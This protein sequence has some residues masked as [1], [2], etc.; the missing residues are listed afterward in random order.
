MKKQ[1]V[2]ALAL[3]AASFGATAGEL[4]YSYV[5]GGYARTHIDNLGNGDG[6]GVDGSVAVSGNIHIFGGYTMQSASED[7]IDVDLNSTRLGVGFNTPINERADFI[8]RA[9]YERADVDVDVP[10]FGSFDGN[11]DGYS[12]EA[13][14]RGQLS[15]DGDIEGWV[16][17][18]Y[19]KLDNAEVED[20]EL[21]T[22]GSD[23][24]EFYGRAGMLFK[25]NPTWGVVA[26]GRFAQ[27]ANQVLV[28]IRASF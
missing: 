6:F 2:L 12:L 8:A 3:A 21:D 9:A 4:S 22:A 18:G 17:G 16:L 25:F 10:G 20:I 5:Q 26:E 28:G 14:F 11:A 15:V 13:G 23:D 24:D 27:D 19:S 7:G 1:I